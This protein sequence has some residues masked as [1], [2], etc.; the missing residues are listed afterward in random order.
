MARY[1]PSVEPRGAYQA[2]RAAA[3][4]G[5]PL[6]TVHYWAREEILVPSISPTRIKLWSYADLMGLRTIYWLRHPK[7][8]GDRNVPATSMPVVRRALAAL[9]DMDLALWTEDSGPSVAVDRAGEVMIRPDADPETVEGQK[10][11]EADELSLIPPF[12]SLEGPQ[13]PDLQAPRPHLRIV[14]GKLGGSPHVQH[15]RV[16]TIALH[17]LAARGLSEDKIHHLYPALSEPSLSEAL[18]LELQLSRNLTLAAST[19]G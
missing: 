18:D 14:P 1:F 11:M 8:A 10:V 5:V 17:A 7:S 13:G 9:K 6:S 16:E 4:S 2:K 12:P 19:N 3:L 15:T